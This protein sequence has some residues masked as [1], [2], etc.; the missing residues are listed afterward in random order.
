MIKTLPDATS[1]ATW[2][3]NMGCQHLRCDNRRVRS[4]DGFLAWP[5]A[6]VDA[7]R[8]VMNAI[9]QGA[10]AALVEAK[11]PQAEW[12]AHGAQDLIAALPDLK[13]QAGDVA[14]AFYGQPSHHLSVV[15]FT[16]TN[17]K[18]SSAWWLAQAMENL[19]RPCGLMGTLGVG[20]LGQ[21]D[22]TG[23]TTPQA[24]DVHDALATMRETGV[25]ACALEA[26]SIGI[27]E[28][29]LQGVRIEVAVFTNLSLDHLDYHRDMA[30]Y[31]AAKRA[32]FDWPDLRAA[33]INIDD[34]H[35]LAL[36]QELSAP[37]DV[38][39][40][41]THAA[42]RLQAL[43]IAPHAQGLSFTVRETGDA[44]LHPVRSTLIGHY[45]VLNLLGVIAS[46]RALGIALADAVA[47]CEGLSAVPG[48]LQRV[49]AGAEQPLV[50]VD[51]AHTPDAVAQ[52]L[53]ALRPLAQARAGQLWT[54]LGCGGD[55][56]PSKRA[57]MAAAAEAGADRLVLT[58]DNPRFEEPQA[59]L[60][61]M[62]CGLSRPAFAVHADRGQAI[63]L[64]VSQASSRDV[65]L[66][67]GKGH[68]DYQEVQGKR[69]PFSDHDIA[70]AALQVRATQERA[71]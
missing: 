41:G 8:F 6:Q 15:A 50:L 35:G 59:I 12:P 64:A 25:H 10:N 68:E 19:G 26:S 44:R 52:V 71:P 20:R 18:T 60:E 38:W 9:D 30:H 31:W 70:L 23:L 34:A 4:G 46:L 56:D 58:S 61:A 51:Y 21:L 57:P 1:A 3:R 65:V 37:I 48:R 27:V 29:R 13:A 5:G 42:A 53:Q 63:A 11:H 43:D 16:G 24:V 40:V 17:G 32:L 49:G 67:A 69:L 62:M 28:H 36:A 54:V 39:S 22:T 2:L 47:A 45:N 66:I 55:R 33:V 7:R 14:H